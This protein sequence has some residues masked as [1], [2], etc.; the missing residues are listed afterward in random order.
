VLPVSALAAQL[1]SGLVGQGHGD[2]D[3][4]ALARV[5]R[6]MSGLED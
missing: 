4:S 5:V 2:E 1:E 6:G 3:M